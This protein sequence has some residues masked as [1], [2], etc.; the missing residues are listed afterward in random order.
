MGRIFLE[1]KVEFLSVVDITFSYKELK[2]GDG[3]NEISEITQ[4]RF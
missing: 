1:V 2:P 4:F 3:M